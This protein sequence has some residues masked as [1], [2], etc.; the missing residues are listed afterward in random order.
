MDLFKELIPLFSVHDR[1]KDEFLIGFGV[2][3]KTQI[4]TRDIL[5]SMLKEFQEIKQV[6]LRLEA[7]Q[8]VSPAKS[9]RRK[10]AKE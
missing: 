10:P 9:K 6:L 8:Q 2:H 4:E 5:K 7:G 1:F 3:N